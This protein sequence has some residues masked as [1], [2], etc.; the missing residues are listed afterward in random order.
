[1]SVFDYL[2]QLS[3]RGNHGKLD[4]DLEVDGD[5]MRWRFADSALL[6]E[7]YLAEPKKNY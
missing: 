5:E 3:V 7:S 6:L 1:M 2:C 4:R